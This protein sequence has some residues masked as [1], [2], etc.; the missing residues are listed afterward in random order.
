MSAT[1]RE[2]VFGVTSD[3]N[4]ALMSQFQVTKRPTLVVV[5]R[6]QAATGDEPEG[7]MRMAIQKFPPEVALEQP[8]VNAWLTQLRT[9]IL[10]V[11]TDAVVPT[12]KTVDA[13]SALD[14]EC[15]AKGGL[16]QLL[17]S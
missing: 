15:A 5:Y 2:F 9:H 13:S 6:E 10:G 1:H 11:D 7:S 17:I 12:P 8:M 3:D 4:E 14:D 16:C